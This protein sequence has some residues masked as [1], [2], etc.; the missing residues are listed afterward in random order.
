MNLREN[1]HRAVHTIFQDETP[2]Q[3]LRTLLEA[4]KPVMRPNIY[5]EI[6]N[7]LKKFEWLIEMWVYEPDCFNEDTFYS[8]FYKQQ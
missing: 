6:S 5:L 2:V 7:V 3:R 1:V 4:D 8:R